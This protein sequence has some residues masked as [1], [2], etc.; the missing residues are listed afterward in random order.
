MALFRSALFLFLAVLITAPA[1]L[2]VT[3]AVVLPMRWRFHIIAV[4]RA[5]FMA[6]CAYVLNLRYRVIGREN[7]PATPS[8]VLSK[9][10][11]AWET[12]GLQAIF[13]PLVFVLKRSLLLIPFLGWAFAAV[14]MI[15]IDRR[16]GKNALKQVEKQGIERL[17]AGYWVVIFPEG[18]RIPPGEHRRF[19]GGGALLAVSAG[20]PAIPVAHNAG[21]FWAKNAF[22]KKPGLITVSIGPAIDPRGKSAEEVNALAEQWIATEMRKISPHRYPETPRGQ[23]G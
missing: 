15:S 1:G 3:L 14:K 4:W 21:E 18:T 20:V 22:V 16:A 19:K 17:R 9:H 5:G 7:I 8:I 13:P 10:Q 6:L 12:V 23:A 2:F 11:S